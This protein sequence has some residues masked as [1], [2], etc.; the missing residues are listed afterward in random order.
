MLR[1]IV[2]A[3]ALMAFSGY[4][5]VIW[6]PTYL[7]RVHGMGT[8]LT[9]TYLALI[10]GVGGALGI[11]LSGRIADRLAARFGPQWPAWVVGIA[12]LISLPF[13]YFT[14]IAPSANAALLAYVVPAGL[15]TVYV[16]CGFAIIQN[17]TPIAMRSVCASINLFVTNMVGLGAGPAW[18]G[19][20]SDRF[21]PTYGI[22]ALRYA[23]L[24]TL[25]V[26]FWSCWHY[27]RAGVC[28]R[29]PA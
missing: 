17:E 26:I 5:A 27:W 12:N 1:N 8:G 7:Q 11:Y 29:D 16:A 23:M 14:F 24:T 13:L 6:V 4:A 21:E 22:D 3:G 28:L 20:M 18:V 2:I 9:G 25:V 19:F 15:G 10:I